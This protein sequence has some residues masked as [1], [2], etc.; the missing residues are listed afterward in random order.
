MRS[1]NAVNYWYHGEGE[2][3]MGPR[4]SQ[5]KKKSWVRWT[6]YSVLALIILVGGYAV[7]Q[8]MTIRN[9]NTT[10]KLLRLMS[11]E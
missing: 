10:T 11:G 8:S 7:Y 4:G 5:K 6:L 3:H 1:I 2:T 9:W